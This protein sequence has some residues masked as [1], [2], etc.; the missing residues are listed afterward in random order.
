[1]THVWNDGGKGERERIAELEGELKRMAREHHAQLERIQTLAAQDAERARVFEGRFRELEREQAARAMR[2]GGDESD[3]FFRTVT[4]EGAPLAVLQLG[5]VPPRVPVVVRLGPD[6]EAACEAMRCLSHLVR[7]G[8]RWL[9]RSA[10]GWAPLNPAGPASSAPEEPES[11][12]NAP[13]GEMHAPGDL[14][15]LPPRQR[16]VD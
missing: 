10:E 12:A 11:S 7:E 13:G 4:F 6:A 1:M 3:V 15:R 8:G 2:M 16:R 9:G 5:P 14:P